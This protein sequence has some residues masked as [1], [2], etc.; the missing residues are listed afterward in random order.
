MPEPGTQPELADFLVPDISSD[1]YWK[2]ALPKLKT[3]IDGGVRIVTRLK[4]CTGTVGCPDKR[5]SV[6]VTCPDK[7]ETISSGEDLDIG[8]S[9]LI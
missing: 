5:S 3:L 6:I 7:G 4:T 2:A 9:V 8:V 1:D